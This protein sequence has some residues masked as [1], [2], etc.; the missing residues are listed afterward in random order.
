MPNSRWLS[1]TDC[2][3]EFSEIMEKQVSE[4]YLSNKNIFK[5]LIGFSLIFNAN[6][7]KTFKVDLRLEAENLKTFS[8]NFASIPEVGFPQPFCNI[9]SDEILVET[10]HEGRYINDYLSVN[11]ESLRHIL[12][13]IGVY[14]VFKMVRSFLINSNFIAKLQN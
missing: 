5:G 4:R 8:R 3:H 10:F 7:S 6:I 12:A 13:K 11:D 9:S 14:T 1:I 2:I